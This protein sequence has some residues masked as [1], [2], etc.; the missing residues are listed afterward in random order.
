MNYRGEYESLFIRPTL[1][2]QNGGSAEGWLVQPYFDWQMDFGR[3]ELTAG[4]HASVYT[5]LRDEV[6]PEPRLS[7]SYQLGQGRLNLSYGL[8]SQLLPLQLNAL[9]SKFQTAPPAP[10]PTK[11]VLTT[12]L[13]R[14]MEPIGASSFQ[15]LR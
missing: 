10:L 1:Q 15:L 3:L 14:S 4:I 8:H 5:V 12:L 9:K 7:L 13:S 11:S 2:W 6:L